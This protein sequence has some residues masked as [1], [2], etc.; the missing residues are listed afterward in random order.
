MSIDKNPRCPLIKRFAEDLQL[1]GKSTRT[2]QSYC[3]ALRK[4]VACWRE[5]IRRFG[6]E[7]G[8]SIANAL[9]DLHR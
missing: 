2:Q 6:K 1:S 4:F 9:T 3:R 5:S 8:M 7:P